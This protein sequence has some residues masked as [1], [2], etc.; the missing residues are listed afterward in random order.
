MGIEADRAPAAP[1]SLLSWRR[2]TEQETL[3]PADDTRLETP[4]AEEVRLAF[5]EA[6]GDMGSLWGVQPSVARVHG[7]LLAHRGVLTEREVRE[8]LDLSHRAASLAL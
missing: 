8:A 6:W 3:R 5:A 1:D 2:M 7:Y 4:T